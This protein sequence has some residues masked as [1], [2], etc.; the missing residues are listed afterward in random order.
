MVGRGGGTTKEVIFWTL[1]NGWALSFSSKICYLI[2]TIDWI[3][4]YIIG[5]RITNLYF[6]FVALEEIKAQEDISETIRCLCSLKV[7][8]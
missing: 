7:F 6:R 2:S 3:I 1:I 4:F 8:F 5:Q